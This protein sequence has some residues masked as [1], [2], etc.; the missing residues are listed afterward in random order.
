ML[1]SELSNP[2]Y[3][4]INL[5]MD[6]ISSWHT[7]KVENTYLGDC[8]VKPPLKCHVSSSLQTQHLAKP[9]QGMVYVPFVFFKFHIWHGLFG[10][11]AIL[12]ILKWGSTEYN[13]WYLKCPRKSKKAGDRYANNDRLSPASFRRSTHTY[14]QNT[15][16]LDLIKKFYKTKF[17][18]Q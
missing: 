17:I 13:M 8:F 3:Q 11:V 1:K 12:P 16:L 7:Y 18:N 2:P 9:T 6:I 4:I 10:H 15:L 14:T 5:A